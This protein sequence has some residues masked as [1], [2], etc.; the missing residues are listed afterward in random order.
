MIW[1]DVLVVVVGTDV[2]SMSLSASLPPSY[3]GETPRGG[4][5]LT[6]SA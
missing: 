5:T 6:A 2:P 4:K 3:S 1:G